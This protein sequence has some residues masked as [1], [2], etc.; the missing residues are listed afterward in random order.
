LFELRSSTLIEAVPRQALFAEQPSPSW[1]AIYTTPRHEK[2]VA[3]HFRQRHIES[4]LPLYC[5]RRRWKDGS[6]VTLQLPLFPNYI[7]AQ[8]RR[9]QRV[10]VLAV[11]GVL[12]IVGSGREPLPLPDVEIE[13][14]RSGLHLRNVEP[15][16]LLVVGEKARIRSG[17]L[18]G[19]QGIVLRRKNDFRV[20]LT[21]DL[22]MRS[23]AVE[24]DAEDLEPLG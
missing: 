20:V 3:E 18:A 12:S 5:I 8:I 1:F 2:S 22:I 13:S 17:A 16:P 15:H 6:R 11:P 10:R 7:F 19:M 24:V 21:L 9:E 4:F 23:I 14:L